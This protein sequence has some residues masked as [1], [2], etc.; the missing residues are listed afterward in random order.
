MNMVLLPGFAAELVAW[1]QRGFPAA[2]ELALA[3][4]GLLACRTDEGHVCVDLV[5][6]AGQRWNGQP[7][8]ELGLW[9]GQLLA[10]GFVAEPGGYAPLLLDGDRLYLARLWSD[11][12]ALAKQLLQRAGPGGALPKQ[13]KAA[14]DPLFAGV[15][16]DDGQRLAAATA[17][18]NRVALIAGGPGTGKTTTVAKVLA[19]LVML[20]PGCR[21]RLAAP[22]G[23]A[24]NRMVE[25]LAG[26]KAKLG[27]DLVTLAE[28]PDQATTLHRLLGYRPDSATPRYG[29][30]QPLA[31][32]VLVVDEASM[33]DLALFSRL[34]QALPPDA[35]LILLGDRDQ[36]ASV[37]AGSAFA[38]LVKLA[39]RTPEGAQRLAAASGS[40]QL[41]RPGATLL[42]DGIAMLSQSHR[43]GGNSGIGEL[44]RRANAGD[45]AGTLA[46][47][48]EQRS[49]LAWQPGRASEWLPPM[50]A[51]LERQLDDYRSAVREADPV[52]AFQAFD[53]LRL[54][55]VVRDGPVGVAAINRLVETRLWRQDPRRQPWYAGRPVIVRASDA[56]LGL[57]NGDIGLCLAGPD[58]LR[59][60]FPQ[61]DGWRALTP[62]RL[63]AHDTAFALTVH[64][65]QGSEF[66][67]VWLLLPDEDVPVLSRSLIY[68]AVTRARREVAVWGSATTLAAALARDVQRASG[69]LD[70]LR[71]AE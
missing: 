37:E 30:D 39:G 28:L 27:L 44:A 26:A 52:A 47:L 53:R 16:A 10:S 64:Q 34:L 40:K 1:L 20:Q 23:K 69:L 11:E 43:F 33:I 45:T 32:D 46:L 55:C 59:V 15:P 17:L 38:E 2:G 25:A 54:L 58:G 63:P 19:A 65:S 13:I 68:T 14:L 4:A 24:A 6:E 61:G 21:I 49:D 35:R 71:S 66:D 9:R 51:Q 62:A 67:A 22:T 48:A 42:G 70:R 18:L 12:V 31:L 5:Q 56:A 60:Y 8:P 57:A 29:A 41:A 7:W 3:S 50:L 36:L